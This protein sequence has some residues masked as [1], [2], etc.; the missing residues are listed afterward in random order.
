MFDTVI[1]YLLPSPLR[2]YKDTSYQDIFVNG[3]GAHTFLVT[4]HKERAFSKL[5]QNSIKYRVHVWT[6]L[7]NRNSTKW[8]NILLKLSLILY[9]WIKRYLFSIW[10][11]QKSCIKLDGGIGEENS[12][13]IWLI[14]VCWYCWS[15][16]LCLSSA[17]Q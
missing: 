1:K 14:K 13:I 11:I 15:H 8:S 9:L 17:R 2:I 4:T 16:I 5:V 3:E 6:W 12:A 10:I 7:Q